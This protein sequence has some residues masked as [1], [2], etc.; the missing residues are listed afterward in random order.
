MTELFLIM[1]SAFALVASWAGYWFAWNLE[2]DGY[3]KMSTFC[4]A[5]SSILLILGIILFLIVVKWFIV[6]IALG[7][8]LIVKYR[9]K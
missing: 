8:W 4:N 2:D 9:K 1:L 5:V 6:V 3:T 7:I